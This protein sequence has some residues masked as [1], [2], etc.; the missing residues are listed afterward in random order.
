MFSAEHL[1]ADQALPRKLPMLPLE[2]SKKREGWCPRDRC[3]VS[4]QRLL[5]ADSLRMS[6]VGGGE[7]VRRL[8]GN[9]IQQRCRD[10]AQTSLRRG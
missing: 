6:R 2:L 5:G 3:P 10:P 4:Q 8:A 7:R 1:V 9:L